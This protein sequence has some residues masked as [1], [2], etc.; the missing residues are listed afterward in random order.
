MN[1]TSICFLSKRSF[2]NL[3]GH[4]IHFKDRYIEVAK[5]AFGK[6]RN[7]EI[8]FYAVSC[9]GVEDICTK[10][11]IDGYPSLYA[12]P[13]NSQ[14]KDRKL[15]IN[16]SFSLTDVESAL[17]VSSKQ[18]ELEPQLD[19]HRRTTSEN[20][21]REH[22]DDGNNVNEKEENDDGNNRSE[23]EDGKNVEEDE[24]NDD[25]KSEK[26]EKE[27]D[28]GKSVKDEKE[29]DDGKN[30]KEEEENGDD[31]DG[32]QE[33]ANE[34]G[35]DGEDG[36]ENKNGDDGQQGTDDNQRVENQNDDKRSEEED[37]DDHSKS[38]FDEEVERFKNGG[39]QSGS[40]IMSSKSK[41]VGA[42]VAKS[43]PKTMDQWKDIMKQRLGE[44]EYQWLRQRRAKPGS[45][46]K[47]FLQVASGI[48]ND[49]ATDIMLANRK[50]TQEY[51][52]RQKALLAVIGK[53]N[54]YRRRKKRENPEEIKNQLSK[55]RLPYKKR[56]RPMK[57]VE[58]VPIVRSIVP[59]S[60]EEELIL[61]ASLSF[62][63]GLR[64]G[65]YKSDYPLPPKQKQ[66]LKDWLELLQ[67]SL[68]PEWALHEAIGDLIRNF[69]YIS[70]G[71]KELV[72]VLSKH[73]FPRNTWSRSCSRKIGFA[74]GFWKLLHTMTVGIAEFRGGQDLILSGSVRPG[75]RVFSPLEAADT[76]RE[77]VAFFFKCTECS[78]HFTGQ[79]NQCDL[80]RRCK[81]LI[82]DSSSTSDADWKEL[83]KWL[84]EFHNDVNVRLHN[85]KGNTTLTEQAK[86][87][88]PSITE[89]VSCLNEDGTFNENTIFL[90]LEQT[91][92][93]VFAWFICLERF[94]RLISVTFL[95]YYYF[96]VGQDMI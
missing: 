4:C 58:R 16:Q 15:L 89:C 10:Y 66:A 20:D 9:V 21:Q 62:L 86:V 83:A 71:K 95:Y 94:Q 12:I 25:G 19:T 73:K 5:E 13:A 90:H 59:V 64:I 38:S 72:D 26:D 6:Y 55:G 37:E 3:Q 8:E 14:I 68:P 88:W 23:K 54:S 61:D 44:R 35:D 40:L 80:N 87:I 46:G 84:W 32:K 96:F 93:Y 28:D 79:Y 39:V 85:E 48:G 52:E 1:F 57:L 77:Y 92:W 67:I 22:N 63:T 70:K 30:E 60:H 31:G 43:L 36:N 65:V 78:T 47:D 91:Y 49:G 45:L 33:D 56:V 69:E 17:N 2:Y 27:N 50:G 75:T 42:E 41:I 34:N 76:V 29:N 82:S 74:C 53:M 7:G 51:T 11:A 24:V 18:T 81:R